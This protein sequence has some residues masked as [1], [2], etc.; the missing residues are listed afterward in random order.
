MDDHHARV[1]RGL[2]AHIL[3]EHGALLRRG[4]R[5][6]RLSD[7]E[8]VVVDRL[9]QSNDAEVVILAGEEGSKVGRSDVG[10]IATDSVQDLD[11]VLD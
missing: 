3:E 10:V 1:G 6:E 9:R 11:A 8:N 5:T 4:P 7:R 2:S